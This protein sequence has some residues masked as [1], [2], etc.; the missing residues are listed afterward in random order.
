MRSIFLFKSLL[1]L[2]KNQ[3][4]ISRLEISF[5]TISLAYRKSPLPTRL[6][7][8]SQYEGPGERGLLLPPRGQR[9]ETSGAATTEAAAALH[10]ALAGGHA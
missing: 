1:R 7:G 9:D 6:N 3:N 10:G 5:K 2:N 4:F 8:P